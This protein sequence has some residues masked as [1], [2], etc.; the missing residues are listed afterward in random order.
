MTPMSPSRDRWSSSPC[1]GAL[2]QGI[3]PAART[4]WLAAVAS[5]GQEASMIPDAPYRFTIRPLSEDEGGGYLIVFLICRA[6]C[7]T[8]TRSSRRSVHGIDAMRGCIEAMGAEGASCPEPTAPWLCQ[9]L[10]RSL[11][12]TERGDQCGSSTD[13][14][15]GVTDIDLGEP[16]GPVETVCV[17]DELNERRNC[18]PAAWCRENRTGCP[19]KWPMTWRRRKGRMS[20]WRCGRR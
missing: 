3:L 7:R 4:P 16:S 19:K 17:S 6:G 14:R 13:L 18:G 20:G 11:L 12:L 9:P 1:E 15:Q 10:E 8:A 5:P 2:G